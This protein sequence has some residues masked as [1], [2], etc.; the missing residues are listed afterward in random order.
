MCHHYAHLR[1]TC[2]QQDLMKKQGPPSLVFSYILN[3]QEYP[4]RIMDEPYKCLIQT[5]EW[6]SP[7]NTEVRADHGS[8]CKEKSLSW[9]CIEHRSRSRCSQTPACSKPF[10]KYSVV[11]CINPYFSGLDSSSED[12]SFAEPSTAL[13]PNYFLLVSYMRDALSYT[14]QHSLSL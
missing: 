5:S 10:P 3:P 4:L 13:V 2:L 9:Y 14:Q 12:V 11:S 1:S 6:N 8:E 7:S